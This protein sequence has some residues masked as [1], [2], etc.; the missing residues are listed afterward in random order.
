METGAKRKQNDPDDGDDEDPMKIPH[1]TGLTHHSGHGRANRLAHLLQAHH[2]SPTRKTVE[3]E[4]ERKRAEVVESRMMTRMK[5][6]N[7]TPSFKHCP[8][9]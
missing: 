6:E 7:D 3:D 4:I 8:L 2:L 9:P 5:K 1:L